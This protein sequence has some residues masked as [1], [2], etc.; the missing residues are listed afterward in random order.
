MDCNGLGRKRPGFTLVE[1]LVLLGLSCFFAGT[2]GVAVIRSVGFLDGFSER[3]FLSEFRLRFEHTRKEALMALEPKELVVEKG[4]TWYG[5]RFQHQ[6]R[7][8]FN[9]AGIMGKGQTILLEKNKG[10]HFLTIQPVTGEISFQT[11]ESSG[12]TG[13]G[14]R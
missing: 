6:V 1:L 10:W 4:S 14:G 8:S 2:F 3:L 5:Y 7:V 11:C 9:A 13:N 12:N